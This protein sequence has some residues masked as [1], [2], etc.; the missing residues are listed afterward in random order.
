[1][2]FFDSSICRNVATAVEYHIVWQNQ[3]IVDV[4]VYITISAIT[5]ATVTQSFTLAFT[6]N[7][8]FSETLSIH[9][10]GNPGYIQGLPVIA[11]T[12]NSSTGI[13]RKS[14]QF[15]S[16]VNGACNTLNNRDILFDNN[17]ISGCALSVPVS[18]FQNCTALRFLVSSIQAHVIHSGTQR[19][20]KYG[21]SQYNVDTDWVPILQAD[22]Y[23]SYPSGGNLSC[24]GIFSSYHLEIAVALQGSAQNPQRM[25]TGALL[26]RVNTTWTPLCPTWPCNST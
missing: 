12:V 23:I 8:K 18:I 19:I 25:I 5:E 2:P 26:R 3:S 14:M 16:G 10:S 24:D 11:E 20:G 6:N 15:L 17:V 4:L 7:G 13:T 21:N 1:M 9:K 22:D